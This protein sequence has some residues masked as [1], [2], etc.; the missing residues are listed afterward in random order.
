MLV[1][2]S[3]ERTRLHGQDPTAQAG[4]GTSGI[5]PQ[6]LEGT[7]SDSLSRTLVSKQACVE[8]ACLQNADLRCS[9]GR[10][11]LTGGRVRRPR[12]AMPRLERDFGSGD[13]PFVAFVGFVAKNSQF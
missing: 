13:S 5:G 9:P 6:E 10:R 12:T 8:Q 3:L 4:G 1:Q 2:A 7:T 11:S